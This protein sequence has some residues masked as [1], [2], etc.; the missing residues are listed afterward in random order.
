MGFEAMQSFA[1]TTVLD[2]IETR[3]YSAGSGETVVLLHNGHAGAPTEVASSLMW[4]SVFGAFAAK[5]HTVALDRLGQGHTAN[6][7]TSAG[8]GHAASVAHTLAFLQSL[9]SGPYHLVG[10]DE[11][12]FVAAQLACAHPDLVASVTLVSANSLTPGS[13]RR[14]IVLSDPLLPLL[15]SAS[16]RWHYER[17]CQ[18]HLA[19][20]DAWMDEATAV[21]G[22]D[23][24]RAAIAVMADEELYLRQQV[25]QWNAQRAALHRIIHAEGLPCPT[26]IVWGFN[27][28]IAPFENARY[29][30]ELLAVRQR[31]TELRVL[32]AAG[33]F[34]HWEQPAAF[35]RAVTSFVAQ[36]KALAAATRARPPAK[37]VG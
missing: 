35:A 17:A 16:L 6:P 28:P 7:A 23:K 10:H 27:D 36:A 4:G 13:D 20:T 22:L 25:G 2:E 3:F 33:H 9:G 31:D 14:G 32:N 26:L 29:L 34:P 37:R 1:R 8:Y 12:A 19:V 5:F 24:T 18:S 11:G 30:M 21:A 15:S